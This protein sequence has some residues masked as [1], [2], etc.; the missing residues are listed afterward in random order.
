M[1]KPCF[2]SRWACLVALGA[3]VMAVGGWFQ[4]APS[5]SEVPA[6]TIRVSTHLVL[7]DVVV[8]DKQGKPVSGLNREDFVLQEKGKAQKIAFFTPSSESQSQPAPALPP[9]IYSNKP[10]YR[11]PG[12]PLV[13]LLLDA[14]NNPIQGPGLCSRA[15][16]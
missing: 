9:G 2:R 10:E 6:P 14:A 1:S 13:I 4:A 7:V 8:T 3:I 15:D 16:A 11:S 12:G 5:N